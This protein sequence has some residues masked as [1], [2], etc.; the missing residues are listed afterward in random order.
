[1]L[2]LTLM[3]NLQKTVNNPN[4]PSFCGLGFASTSIG[5]ASNPN[6]NANG[7]MST[8]VTTN[9]VS[10]STLTKKKLLE[11]KELQCHNMG[12]LCLK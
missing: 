11:A 4:D 8:I 6:I 5:C 9:E 1:M 7:N 3:L 2:W 12:F 10:S